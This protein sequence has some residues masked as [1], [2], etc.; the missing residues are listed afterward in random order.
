VQSE[1]ML[2]IDFGADGKASAAG[3][4]FGVGRRVP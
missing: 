2:E 1:K 4:Q 3:S